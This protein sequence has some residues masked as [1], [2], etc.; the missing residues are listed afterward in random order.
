MDLTFNPNVT[1]FS[2]SGS[3][4]D[5]GFAPNIPERLFLCYEIQGS[6]VITRNDDLDC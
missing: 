1:T 5:K 3:M 6:D 4:R 2:S